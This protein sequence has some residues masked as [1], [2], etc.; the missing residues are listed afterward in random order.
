MPAS[1]SSACSVVRLALRATLRGDF[2]RNFEARDPTAVRISLASP[3]GGRPPLSHRQ[4]FAQREIERLPRRPWP[5]CWELAGDLGQPVPGFHL[6]LARYLHRWPL[7][8]GCHNAQVREEAVREAIAARVAR[9]DPHASET[10]IVYEFGLC[11]AEARI[12]VATINGQLTGWEIK[13]RRDRL[14]RLPRQEA[15][16]SRVFD[17]MWLVAAERHIKQAIQLIPAWWGVLAID[18]EAEQELR[19]VRP[20][21]LNEYVD[22]HSLVRLLWRQ[23]AVEELA[24]LGLSASQSRA[25]RRVLWKMLADAAPEWISEADLRSRVRER[26][27][28]RDGWRV[29]RLPASGGGWS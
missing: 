28:H 19:L 26:L 23:E 21:G 27:K 3:Q 9:D 12:D 4:R 6:C 24:A 1:Q 2:L 18:S 15:V 17:R 14:T 20:A 22:R 10:R 13:T 8:L 11:Q 16:Y 25:P 5:V 7:A 29:D